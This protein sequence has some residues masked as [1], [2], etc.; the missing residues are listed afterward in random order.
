MRFVV[1]GVPKIV[2]LVAAQRL[3]RLKNAHANVVF[4]AQ[5]LVVLWLLVGVGRPPPFALYGT[6]FAVAYRRRVLRARPLDV[7]PLAVAQVRK[8]FN[9]QVVLFVARVVAPFPLVRRRVAV[10]V[11]AKWAQL[12]YVWRRTLPLAVGVVAAP[13]YRFVV[14]AIVP[15]FVVPTR[16][17]VA[18]KRFYPRHAVRNLG[19]FLQRAFAARVAAARPFN[20]AAGNRFDAVAFAVFVVPPRLVRARLFRTPPVKNVAPKP[21]FGRRPPVIPMLILG[22]KRRYHHV[23]TRKPK[24]PTDIPAFRRTFTHHLITD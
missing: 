11:A 7:P 3:A 16:L 14:G 13:R 21:L 8:P 4:R 18:R 9:Q 22:L 24:S 10:N 5:P 19:L 6:K 2:V 17:V 23:P 20:R 12:V 1:A 15:A